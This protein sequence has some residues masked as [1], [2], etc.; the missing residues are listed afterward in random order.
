M[1]Y[2]GIEVADC[3]EQPVETAGGVST[4]YR[5]TNPIQIEIPH[6]ATKMELTPAFAKG[7]PPRLVLLGRRDF[8][9]HFRVT[10]DERAQ[11]FTLDPYG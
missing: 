5:W 1:A 9:A 7:L 2:L 6:M 4:Q 10:V 11:T 8:F 3:E